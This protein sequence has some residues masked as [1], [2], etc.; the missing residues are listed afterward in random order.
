MYKRLPENLKKDLIERVR[1][2]E[3]LSSVCLEARVSRTIFYRW[4]KK[5]SQST[6]STAKSSLKAASIKHPKSFNKKLVG[7]IVKLSLS[8]PDWSV[9]QIANAAG[10]SVHEAWNVLNRF[11]LSTKKDRDIYREKHGISIVKAIHV[12]VK[13]TI[14]KRYETGETATE[15]C[16]K[17]GISRTIFYRWLKRYQ[18]Q[19]RK[20]H[21][22]RNTFRGG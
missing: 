15:L 19:G 7:M 20:E 11:N 5:Y 9:R 14:I 8:N 17:F 6:S 18:A 1:K 10:V 21:A 12:D 22:L 4:L 13:H 16:N 2:G 3:S